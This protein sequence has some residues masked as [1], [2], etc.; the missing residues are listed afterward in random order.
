MTADDH[1]LRPAWAAR[2]WVTDPLVPALL[3]VIGSLAAAAYGHPLTWAMIGGLT[4][5]TLSGS[6]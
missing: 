4:G 2:R 6:V 5:Y 1:V 3:L